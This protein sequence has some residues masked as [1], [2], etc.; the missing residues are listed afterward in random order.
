MKVDTGALLVVFWRW[1][2]MVRRWRRPVGR[3]PATRKLHVPVSQANS[4]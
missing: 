4:A 2:E 3:A 1:A